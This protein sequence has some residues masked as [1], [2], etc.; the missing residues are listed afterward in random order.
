MTNWRPIQIAPKDG[1]KLTIRRTVSGVTRYEG[2]ATWQ[3][4]TPD[5]TGGWIDEDGEPVPEPTHWK[6]TG[7]GRPY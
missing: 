2:V 5:R 4:A 6:L 7:R 3:S 1:R